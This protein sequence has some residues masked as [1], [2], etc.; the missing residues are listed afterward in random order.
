MAGTD[1]SM[2]R[3][4]TLQ[5]TEQINNVQ[6]AEQVTN[7]LMKYF[8]RLGKSKALWYLLGISLLFFLLRF[9]SF[10][11]PDW[12]VDD[13]LF[14]AIGLALAKGQVLY[15]QI[16][17]NK[18]PLVYLLFALFHSELLTLRLVSLL[19]GLLS[20]LASFF[21]SQ[22]LFGNRQISMLTTSIFAISFATPI[23]E[24]NVL[25]AENFMLLPIVTAGFLIYA[26]S[27]SHTNQTGNRSRVYLLAGVLLGIAFLLQLVAVFDFSAFLL[28]LLIINLPEKL[29]FL[30]KREV[31]INVVKN[32]YPVL[33]GFLLPL[34]ITILYFL[35]QHTL[36]NFL[37]AVFSGNV[38]YVG[39]DNY[40][41]IPQ[42]TLLLK[43]LLLIVAV[44]LVFL[45]RRAF[46]PAA[47][48][49]LL[50]FSFSLFNALFSG[51][52]Y[53]HYLLSVLPSISLVAGLCFA[54]QNLK[55][56]TGI[57]L[58]LILG[59]CLL[60][61]NFGLPNF[62]TTIGYYRYS[63]LFE[64]G[65]IDRTVYYQKAFGGIPTRNDEVAQF[66]KTHTTP[67]ESV[68]VW[69]NYP[70]VYLLAGRQPP[71]KYWTAFQITFNEQT[72]KETELALKRNPPTYIIVLAKTQEPFPFEM[73]AYTKKFALN[74]AIIYERIILTGTTS[75]SQGEFI[76]DKAKR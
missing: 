1:L 25:H 56:R 71:V 31:F 58:S 37:E 59:L 19:F 15:V 55:A 64:A 66:I 69:G 65:R 2:C 47:I 18:P 39:K 20:V 43:V 42:G 28:Y 60:V 16:S 32:I 8:T 9:T 33:V 5:Q 14:E 76:D 40:L 46:P 63:L 62:R 21:L 34:F 54:T 68:F 10:F 17:D 75:S 57:F 4:V 7:G 27:L 23:F 36:K 29:S 30:Q 74:G 6:Q 61:A 13:G 44:F 3:G 70:Q 45:K 72:L 67:S 48:F 35:T 22:R 49:I 41:L 26:H 38:G 11:E 50:W 52:G 53:P 73:T 24:G 12:H 51:R